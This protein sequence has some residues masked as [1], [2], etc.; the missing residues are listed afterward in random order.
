VPATAHRG[1]C[2]GRLAA[3][4]SHLASAVGRTA[5]TVGPSLHSTYPLQ[6]PAIGSP[7]TRNPNAATL[8]TT[9]TVDGLA[10][11]R[12]PHL[13]SPATAP[14]PLP[15]LGGTESGGGPL[16]AFCNPSTPTR[17]RNLVSADR[18]LPSDPPGSYLK[19]LT[20][21]SKHLLAPCAARSPIAFLGQ[22]LLVLR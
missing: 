7:V 13:T 19:L 3:L 8:T 18:T 6:P 17:A 16:M 22:S 15:Y 14:P 20:V 10:S 2:P 5:T 21:P 4:P 9:P 11:G 12:S 1:S